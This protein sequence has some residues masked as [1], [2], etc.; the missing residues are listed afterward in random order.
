MAYK[1]NDANGYLEA[2]PSVNGLKEIKALMKEYDDPR[3]ALAQLLQY[4]HTNMLPAL[5]VE[6]RNLSNKTNDKSIKH[7]LGTIYR[8][9]KK[10]NEIL[11]LEH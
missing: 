10:A 6:V 3:P 8:L 9:S 4:G 5:A 1:F 2:G 11:V 7:T